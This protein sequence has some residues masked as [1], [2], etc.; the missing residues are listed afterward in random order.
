[1][2]RRE[3]LAGRGAREELGPRWDR[4]GLQMVLEGRRR[5]REAGRCGGA[6]LV[7][8][9]AL[10]AAGHWQRAKWRR[11]GWSGTEMEVGAAAGRW[12]WRLLVGGVENMEGRKEC[13]ELEGGSPFIG[14][15]RVWGDL[16]GFRTLR[17]PSY[18][19]GRKKG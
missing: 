2:Q 19:S 9:S 10:A 5:W 16:W 3:A 4:G 18:G 17:S 7:G 11:G 1:M 13:P 14:R 8:A 6:R 12:R 15:V